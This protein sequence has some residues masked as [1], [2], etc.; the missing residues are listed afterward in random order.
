MEEI[1]QINSILEGGEPDNISVD[2]YSGYSGYTPQSIIDAINEV[3]GIDKWGFEELS[4]EI[5]GV[6]TKSGLGQ[7]S[8]ANV[9]VWIM[10]RNNYRTA[11]GQSRVTSG[12]VGDAMKGAQTDALKKALS[13]FSIGSKAYLGLLDSK[14][15]PRKTVFK[16]TK[17]SDDKYYDFSSNNLLDDSIESSDSNSVSDSLRKRYFSLASKLGIDNPK[18]YIKAKFEVDSFNDLSD[19]Q[20]EWFIRA[21]EKKIK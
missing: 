3:I 17:T 20:V 13:Y 15:K 21:L 1:E 2:T 10:D 18:E 14:K 8:L 4:N 11:H 7:L 16:S 9:K 5:I 6:E 12:D 19:T